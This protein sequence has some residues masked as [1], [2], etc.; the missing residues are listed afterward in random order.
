MEA[1]ISTWHKTGHF[2]FALTVRRPVFEAAGQ[3]SVDN[4]LTTSSHRGGKSPSVLQYTSQGIEHLR[5]LLFAG[6]GG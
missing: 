5:F 6:A 3:D 2:Y 4:F 1:D